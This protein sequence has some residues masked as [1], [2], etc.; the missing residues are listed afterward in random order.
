MNISQ[1]HPYYVPRLRDAPIILCDYFHWSQSYYVS[2]FAVFII[3]VLFIIS[4]ITVPWTLLNLNLKVLIKG[5]S[6]SDKPFCCN[7]ELSKGNPVSLRGK[8]RKKS[9]KWSHSY[10]IWIAKS[11][12]IT[13]FKFNK[14]SHGSVYACMDWWTRN[15]ILM[16]CDKYQ[17]SPPSTVLRA[18][19]FLTN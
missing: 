3:F 1:I 19:R 11:V 4:S 8:V 17:F 16:N 7:C 18:L 10:S 5:V 12:N 13:G 9:L 14:Y 6:Y 15:D 2:P